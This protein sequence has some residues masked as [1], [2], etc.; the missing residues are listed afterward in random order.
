MARR[1]YW[2]AC[3]FLGLINSEAGKHRDCL[4]VWDEAVS[5]N[6]LI[7]TSFFTWA[8]VFKKK[9]EGPGKPLDEAGDKNIEVVLSQAFVEPVLVDETIATAARR[10]MRAHP[11]CKKPSDAIYLATALRLGALSRTTEAH[12]RSEL[13]ICQPCNRNTKRPTILMG[14][15]R[16]GVAHGRNCRTQEV[17]RA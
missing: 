6:T 14:L 1:V 11:A 16:Y 13:V 9:C 7:I 8:E 5:G 10:L 2:D 12:R 15:L 17:F 4:A 3:V